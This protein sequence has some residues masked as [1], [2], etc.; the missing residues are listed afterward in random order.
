[1]KINSSSHFL[2]SISL[3]VLTA[4]SSSSFADE[5]SSDESDV[6]VITVSSDLLQRDLVSLPASATVVTEELINTKQVR[7]L[8]DLTSAVPNLNFSA[9][10]SRGR[11]IQIRGIGERS[12]FSEPVNPSI[13]LFLDDIDISGMGALATVFDLVQVEVLSGPQ[14]VGT[15]S[16][17]LGGSI[18]LVSNSAT[19]NLYANVSAS[20][21]QYDE[22]RLS[23]VVSNRINDTAS[24]RM[25]AQNTRSDGFVKNG[26]LNRDDTNGINETSLTTSFELE[27]NENARVDIKA[28]YFDIDN[29]YDAFSL[30]NNN[31]TQSDEPGHDKATASAFSAKYTGLVGKSQF[32][33][34]TYYLTANTDY[35]YDEDWT[36]TGFHPFGYTSFDQYLRS[37]DRSGFDLKLASDNNVENQYL[38]GMSYRSHDEEFERIYTFAGPYSS[39]YTPKSL[40]LYGQYVFALP[41]SSNLSFAGRI[42]NFKADFAD[43]QDF[44]ASLDDTLFAAAVTI[45]HTINS[46]LLF[47]SL[48]TGYKAG[49]F[50]IDPRLEQENMTFD[51]EYNTSFELGVKGSA[52]D[53]TAKLS[54]TFFYM[55]RKDAQVSDFAVFTEQDENGATITSFADVIGNS[56]SGINKGIELNSTWDISEDWQILANLG[57][58]DATFG[59]YTKLNGDEVLKIEQAQAPSYTAYLSSRYY[60]SDGLSWF[61]DLE[62]KDSFRFS[63]GH[64]YLAPE[65]F[66]VNSQVDWQVDNV[67]VS[68]WVKNL[69]DRTIY[70]RGF[71]SFSNDPRDEYAFAEPYYQTGQQRQFG[72]SVSYTWE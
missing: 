40:S 47:A 28:Y 49:G 61:I 37:I 70:T 20:Y 11:F 22:I 51:P 30:D 23:G 42:E 29:G 26:F 71:G 12:Q 72:I 65:T 63:D 31:V 3:A 15:G 59:G 6:E 18:R 53:D 58:L 14:S 13:G 1:M 60:F 41:A 33:A 5:T 46:S 16:N 67:N 55:E 21:A 56:D 45:D 9:G 7:H 52:F 17:S 69:F 36:F 62:A 34:S 10:A 44:S 57:Y 54:L 4:L 38:V 48:S 39:V 68:F 8:Q 32:Q 35:A 2:S 27:L 50:N 24:F 64:D 43:T 66:V 19:E 25:S